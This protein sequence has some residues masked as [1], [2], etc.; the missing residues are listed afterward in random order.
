MT[1]V[2]YPETRTSIDAHLLLYNWYLL[3][4]G[5]AARL[6]GETTVSWCR[7]VSNKAS[8]S[9]LAIAA[10]GSVEM[11]GS[12]FRG[13]VYSC[14]EGEYLEEIS[15]VRE[16]SFLCVCLSIVCIDLSQI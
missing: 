12:S 5:G 10:V 16:N 2:A 11:N 4:V 8:S 6:G 1:R 15:N 13:N 3:D 9:G 14:A 7:F